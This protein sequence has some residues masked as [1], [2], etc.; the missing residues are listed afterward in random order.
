MD[1]E[2]KAVERDEWCAELVALA[3]R[4]REL[5]RLLRMA[6]WDLSVDCDL[7]KVKESN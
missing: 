2:K 5:Y 4:D 7:D 6:A 1:D 3:I